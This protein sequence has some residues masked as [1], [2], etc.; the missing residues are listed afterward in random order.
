MRWNAETR[1]VDIGIRTALALSESS[2]PGV[3][4]PASAARARYGTLCHE[5]HRRERQAQG[6]VGEVPV[7]LCRRLRGWE[8]TLRGRVD[9]VEDGERA[10][11]VDEVKSVIGPAR[12]TAVAPKAMA[13]AVA[14][15]LLYALALQD[16]TLRPAQVLRPRVV[17]V[18][19]DPG[20]GPALP[21][22]VAFDVEDAERRLMTA[23][24]AVVDAIQ[25]R[26]AEHQRRTA[27]ATRLT[28]PYRQP[29]PH[30]R[31]LAGIVEEALAAERPV[32]LEAPTGIGKTVAALYPAL[33]HALGAGAQTH[34]LTA[35]TTQ[36]Q[37]VA[38]AFDDL[39]TAAGP[40]VPLVA[41]TLR[42]K[43]QMCPPGHLRCHPKQCELLDDF[44]AR[45]LS[46]ELMATL[47]DRGGHIDPGTVCTEASLQRLCPYEVMRRLEP[48]VDLVIGDYNQ[49]FDRA[50][51]GDE[52]P[53]VVID[54][55]HNLFDRAREL[56]SPFVS[57]KL[58]QQA[59]D[60][61]LDEDEPRLRE[62]AVAL[63]TAVQQHIE[64]AH[65]A[66]QQD[67][68]RV[69]IG[70]FLEHAHDVERWQRLG[71]EAEALG[72]RW[73][74]ARWS[75]QD[76]RP[77]D[78]VAELVEMVTRMAR[79]IDK[80]RTHVGFV[81]WRDSP[82]G[83]GVGLV[84]V[85]P[86]RFLESHHRRARGVVVMSA[87]LSPSAYY[88][89]V[90]GLSRLD[91]VI[92]SAPSPFPVE[93][94]EIVVVPTVKTTLAERQ[95][96]LPAIAQLVERTIAVEPG[97]YIVFLPSH[98][99]LAELRKALTLSR[100]EVLMQPPGASPAIRRRLLRKLADADRPQLLLA[101]TGGVFAEGVD[102]PGRALI[103]AIIVGPTLPPP[104]FERLL[105]QR[106][107]EERHEAGFAYAMVYPGLR[108]V[109]QAAGRVIRTDDD[110]GVIMLLGERFENPS[111]AACLPP[112][113]YRHDVRELSTSD[114]IARLTAFWSSVAPQPC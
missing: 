42:R 60:R 52:A 107:F 72:L 89:E 1:T 101:V 53:V 70:G 57:S 56:A 41:L 49:R 51:T 25:A 46:S 22:D 17:L 65:A 79:Q 37:G 2:Q 39:V 78:P 90:L 11:I 83:E 102:L 75:A 106:H 105:M 61:A 48:R 87:T 71:L 5:R 54:E 92:T 62:A 96:H 113:W 47:L 4:R 29:R 80:A 32:L 26:L 69:P 55:A 16:E 97:N 34:Y 8:V 100:D 82:R 76:V 30:Q 14:Q 93:H 19:V 109:I 18:P 12:A 66:S 94:R 84:C 15:V 81:A 111:Y 112:H 40:D 98:A 13:A 24:G 74:R 59:R 28:F 36:R 58:V 110:V 45:L 21:I 88:A 85:D 44:E 77:D 43:D 63:T 64:Q 108:R 33:R 68:E 86:A 10:R 103:G 31:E 104:T 9:L 23:T 114:P 38:K 27:C 95:A 99:M 73:Q 35:K 3:G 6:A 91:P 7:S 50:A 20:D 67:G